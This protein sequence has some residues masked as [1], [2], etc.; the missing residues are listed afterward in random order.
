MVVASFICA[1][2]SCKGYPAR[3]LVVRYLA[4][5]E[6]ISLLPDYNCY[7]KGNDID[8]RLHGCTVAGL[9]G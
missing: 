9:R 8:I 5:A 1:P 3:V 4:N 6:G 7:R 2:K